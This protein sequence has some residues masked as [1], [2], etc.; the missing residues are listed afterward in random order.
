MYIQLDNE[1]QPYL[2]KNERLL[3]IGNPKT[4]LK[5]RSTDAFI[6]PFS[7]FWLGF[8]VFWEYSA[9]QT[10]VSFF[11]LFGIP[12]ILIGLY[13]LAGRFFVDAFM[14]KNT[15]YGITENR[16]LIRSGMFAKEL[17]SYE[18]ASLTNILFKEQSDGSGTISF[19]VPLQNNVIM[20]GRNSWSGIKLPAAF[21]MI[22]D[23][24]EVYS[25]IRDQQNKKI[26]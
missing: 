26:V 12:F 18:I 16:L 7:I 8:A 15:K 5:L 20:T 4:G 22:S 9:L 21:E 10:G 17:Q 13:L 23:V 6:I 25:L 1:L 2:D 11:A 24:K 14:R 19:G 3:W